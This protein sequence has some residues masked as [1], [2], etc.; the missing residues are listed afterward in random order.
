MSS[1]A[2]FSL[3]F[4]SVIYSGNDFPVSISMEL[5]LGWL[6]FFGPWSVRCFEIWVNAHNARDHSDGT[7]SEVCLRMCSR[8]AY[9]WVN[10]PM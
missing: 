7:G 6:G 8:I 9:V 10:N 3:L 1:L 2:Y 4:A 5:L